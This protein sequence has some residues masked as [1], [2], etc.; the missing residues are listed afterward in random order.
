MNK[1]K[2]IYGFFLAVSVL[3]IMAVPVN[4]QDQKK[5]F[6]PLISSY[7]RV[8]IS[9]K[10]SSEVKVEDRKDAPP[11]YITTFTFAN[12]GERTVR[13]GFAD[14]DTSIY[15][16]L[17]LSADSQD[18]SILLKPNETKTI[19]IK[20]L[21]SPKI[22]PTNELILVWRESLGK[23][24]EYAFNSSATVHAPTVSDLD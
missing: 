23:W 13:F 11:L 1:A 9:F 19:F 8:G 20:T 21:K 7:E 15:A 5:E 14:P 16:S 6:S 4:G 12:K 3:L 18:L 17:A 24:E 10:I 22:I 2:S